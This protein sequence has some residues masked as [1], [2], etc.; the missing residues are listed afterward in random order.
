[1]GLQYYKCSIYDQ[2]RNKLWE[3]QALENGKPSEGWNGTNLQGDE[4]PQG[5]Y[6]WR[7]EAIFENADVWTGDNNMSGNIETV[8]GQ[9]LLLRK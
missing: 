3:T 9:I 5:I 7:A 2:Y 4:M 8:Q 6:V 1:M